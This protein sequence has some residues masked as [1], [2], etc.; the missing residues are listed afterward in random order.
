MPVNLGTRN[1][2]AIFGESVFIAFR[3]LGF[4]TFH[5]PDEMSENVPGFPKRRN[6]KRGK[7]D[8]RKKRGRIMGDFFGAKR[9]IKT[10]KQPLSGAAAKHGSVSDPKQKH[11]PVPDFFL[12]LLFSDRQIR[13]ASHTFSKAPVNKRAPVA[14]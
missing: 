9:F 6:A 13:R 3:E 1:Q 12:F 11:T 5:F 8:S 14:S 10:G 2:K 4:I 7:A